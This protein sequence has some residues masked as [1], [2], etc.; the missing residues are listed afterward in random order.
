MIK[1]PPASAGGARDVD[2][3]PGSGRF[4]GEGNGNPLQYSC[5]GNPMD[6]GAWWVT[7][8]GAT[9]SGTQLRAHTQSLFSRGTVVFLGVNFQLLWT[10]GSLSIL[11]AVLPMRIYTLSPWTSAG[12]C[13]DEWHGFSCMEKAVEPW[14]ALLLP[15]RSHRETPI[16]PHSSSSLPHLPTSSD[17]SAA[18][19]DVL[20]CSRWEQPAKLNLKENR[21]RNLSRGQMNINTEGRAITT[22]AHQILYTGDTKHFQKF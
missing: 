14:E 17:E 11:K 16:F 18:C 22:Q 1:N 20:V 12:T 8:H 5:L 4:P 3:I 21:H 19:Q 13:R 9:K 7:V 6:R 10:T 2:S 15:R